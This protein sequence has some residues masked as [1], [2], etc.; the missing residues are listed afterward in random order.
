YLNTP[1]TPVVVPL[2]LHDALP[3]YLISV[4]QHVGGLKQ[5]DDRQDFPER[6]DVQA[7]LAD[8]RRVRIDAIGAPIGRR[9]GQ[10]DNLASQRIERSEEHTSE[11]QSPDQIVCRLLLE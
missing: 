10:G 8:G 1:R 3:I 2:A 9:D 4:G 7:Q 11:L 5:G 6:L